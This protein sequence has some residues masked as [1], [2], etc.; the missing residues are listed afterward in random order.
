MSDL[1]VRWT[2]DRSRPCHEASPPY[3][4]LGQAWGTLH[5]HPATFYSCVPTTKRYGELATAV[6]L[7]VAALCGLVAQ[8]TT[9]R[10]LTKVRTHKSVSLSNREK[11]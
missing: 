3:P 11:S 1:D 2:I 6:V 4:S 9:T 10:S 8:S 5:S 7:T